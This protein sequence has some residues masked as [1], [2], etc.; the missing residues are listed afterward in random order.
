MKSPIAFT[1]LHHPISIFISLPTI[2]RIIRS[3][4]RKVIFIDKVITGIIWRIDI[5]HFDL[6]KICLLQELQGIKVIAF[7]VDIFA[8][9]VP[10][11]VYHRD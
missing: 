5:N 6:T 10:P 2:I 11:L 8:I 3:T 9:N 7:D 4:L 1:I